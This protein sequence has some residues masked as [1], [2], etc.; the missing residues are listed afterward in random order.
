MDQTTSRTADK[1]V[2]RLP[3]GMRDRIAQVARDNTRSMNSEIINRLEQSLLVG[4]VDTANPHKADLER[5]Y[6]IIDRL[7]QAA[8]PSTE[9]VQEILE[10]FKC[11]TPSAA[12]PAM[13]SSAGV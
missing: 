8:C 3:D 4:Q 12:S 7:L 1:F 5:A 9:D 13:N 10:L 11:G 6:K 2:V